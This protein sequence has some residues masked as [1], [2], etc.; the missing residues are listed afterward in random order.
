MR[1]P[2]IIWNCHGA[3]NAGLV[4]VLKTCIKIYKVKMVA[5]LETRVNGKRVDKQLGFSWSHK[6]E[7]QVFSRGT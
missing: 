6:V 2:I 7:A 5:L 3:A 4:Q 1:F